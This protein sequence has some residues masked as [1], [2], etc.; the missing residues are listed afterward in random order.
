MDRLT[1]LFNVS[2]THILD[3]INVAGGSPEERPGEDAYVRA[4]RICFNACASYDRLLSPVPGRHYMTREQKTLWSHIVRRNVFI[5]AMHEYE[6]KL[7]LVFS[8]EERYI[9]YAR[10][11]LRFV[12]YLY[13]KNMV[14]FLYPFFEQQLLDEFANPTNWMMGRRRDHQD[15]I[16]AISGVRNFEHCI[17]LTVSQC[18]GFATILFHLYVFILIELLDG[19]TFSCKKCL[20][21]EKCETLLAFRKDIL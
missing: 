21:F 13:R 14:H 1:V 17:P 4:K 8:P 20:A 12:D 18:R 9:I 19:E 7:F 11:L 5:L 16:A 6:D 2:T 15:A 3:V 10:F